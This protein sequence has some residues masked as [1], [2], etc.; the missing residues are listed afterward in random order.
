[1]MYKIHLSMKMNCDQQPSSSEQTGG[2][3]LILGQHAALQI[4][5]SS[6]FSTSFG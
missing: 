2:V 1:M 3:D 5:I 6:A 4:T